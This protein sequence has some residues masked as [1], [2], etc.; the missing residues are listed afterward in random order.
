MSNTVSYIDPDAAWQFIEANG[1]I[2]WTLLEP[3]IEQRNHIR[4]LGGS[5]TT[6]DIHGNQVS[7][8]DGL[9]VA[10]E[11]SRRV[12]QPGHFPADYEEDGFRHTV[13][14]EL[15]PAQIYDFD[16]KPL[17]PYPYPYFYP[18][19]SRCGIWIRSRREVPEQCVSGK[20]STESLQDLQT[21]WKQSKLYHKLVQDVEKIAHNMRSVNSIVCFGLYRVGL[22]IKEWDI[23]FQRHLVAVAIRDTLETF[24]SARQGS[25]APIQ[26]FA[27]DLRYCEDCES[28]LKNLLGITVVEPPAGFLHVDENTFVITDN[29]VGNFDTCQWTLDKTRKV[30]GPA[31]LLCDPVEDDG[32]GGR[33]VRPLYSSPQ[34]LR[35]TKECEEA[36]RVLALNSDYI[37]DDETDLEGLETLFAM[38]NGKK[39]YWR[40][41]E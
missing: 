1:F 36:G 16:H 18:N 26:I 6:K 8:S 19:H 14:V 34:L 35:W 31:A 11:F 22:G 23:T 30:G 29:L 7:T 24:R 38:R 25:C 5:F 13:D 41:K 4:K 10:P 12:V 20:L 37:S 27:Q 17:P 9:I 33:N 39:L 3:A 2:D 32:R 21:S 15:Q 28:I 40:P